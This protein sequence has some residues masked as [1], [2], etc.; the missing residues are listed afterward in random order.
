MPAFGRIIGWFIEATQLKNPD[1]YDRSSP[2]LNSALQALTKRTADTVYAG[3]M[4]TE[5]SKREITEALAA[6][7]V[8]HPSCHFGNAKEDD[9]AEQ[10]RLLWAKYEEVSGRS[11][12]SPRPQEIVRVLI[13]HATVE[14]AIRAGGL[15]WLDGDPAAEEEFPAW[16][17]DEALGTVLREALEV[18][19]KTRDEAVAKLNQ[20]A[21]GNSPGES[22]VDR[23]FDELDIPAPNHIRHWDMISST[24]TST[25]GAVGGRN[26][27]FRT[28][29]GRRI[30][31]AARGVAP[32]E[33]L[34]EITGTYCRIKRSIFNCFSKETAGRDEAL[35]QRVLA[36]VVTGRITDPRMAHQLLGD[37]SDPL[38]RRHVAAAMDIGGAPTAGFAELWQTWIAIADIYGEVPPDRRPANLDD[39]ARIYF[40]KAEVGGNPS[41]EYARLL[42]MATRYESHGELDEAETC[43][44]HLIQLAPSASGPWEFLGTL[45]LFQNRPDDAV[46][47]YSTALRLE[48]GNITARGKLISLLGSRG[49]FSEAEHCLLACPQEQRDESD[50]LFAKGD[51]LLEQGRYAQAKTELLKCVSRKFMLHICYQLL[52]IA[53]AG[54]GQTSEEREYQKRAKE[55]REAK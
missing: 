27:L 23:W 36:L 39:F 54:L 16:S 19:F 28:F 4:V 46:K 15:A 48:P 9:L 53:A 50:W 45:H 7:L 14:L 8:S 47:C 17:A 33:M 1:S 40:R 49:R 29:V 42:E 32:A 24:A 44:R 55:F 11:T 26:R 21:H 35:R 22:E 52:A 31:L 3:E 12:T 6:C 20:R 41:A 51:L 18:S 37:Q 34:A 13:R 25:A 2:G 10:L 43:V 30:W 38:W 5:K